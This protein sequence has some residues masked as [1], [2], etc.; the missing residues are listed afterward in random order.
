MKNIIIAIVLFISVNCVATIKKT[1][2]PKE[3]FACWKASYEEN[4]EK[5]KTEIY[6][7]CTN[8]FRPSMFRLSIE[9]FKDGKC[10]YLHAGPTDIHYFVDGKWTY[11]SRTKV[12]TVLDDKKK[13]A[14]KFKVIEANGDILKISSLL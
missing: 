13:L 12:V 9:F 5:A 2:L 8:E 11:N 4:D 3:F 6:R 7:P 1:P 14:Y 10:K